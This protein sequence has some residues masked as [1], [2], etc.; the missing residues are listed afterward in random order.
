MR[1]CFTLLEIMVCL[2]I[3]ALMASVIGVQA[4]QTLEGSRFQNSVKRLKQEVEMLQMLAL[5]FGSDMQL[6]LKQEKNQFIAI[7]HTDEAV[8]KQLKGS[9][10]TLK[11]VTQ[12][13]WNKKA[14]VKRLDILS[15]GR[16][17]P[18]GVLGIRRG[19]EAYYLDFRFPI[20]IKFSQN[21][22]DH[23]EPLRKPEKPEEE[24]DEDS[25]P[26]I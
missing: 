5:I 11:G 2:A 18:E 14:E 19:K 23:F 26:S 15:N 9:K 16:V 21:Y 24:T 10:I 1:R 12:L 7:T 4:K 22:N 25:K 3:M 20:Q 6:E 8:L 17:W 13:T